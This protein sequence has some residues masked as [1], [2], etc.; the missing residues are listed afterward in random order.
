MTPSRAAFLASLP[1][2]ASALPAS[3]QGAPVLRV[4]A[5]PNDSFAEAY[6]AD[7]MGFFRRAGLD[8]R[9]S[10]FANGAQVTTG[11]AAGA[12]D[13]GISSVI[14]LAN[15]TL[16]GLPF[17]YLAGGGM[18][19]AAAPTIVLCVAK[20]APLREAR[21]LEGTTVTV[22]GIRDI[23]HLAL[24]TWLSRNG[25]DPA[26]VKVIEM[27]FSSVGAALRRGAVAAGI[28]SE[29]SL[30]AASDEVRVFAK[31]FDTI[32]AR[33]MIGGWFA[34]GD[35]IAKNRALA[36]RFAAVIH[37]TASWAN[38]NHDRSAEI[39]RKYTRIG[40]ATM[41][42]MTRVTYAESLEPAMIA[43][44]LEL[45][46]KERFLERPVSPSQMIARL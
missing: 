9:I 1:L 34:R 15:A 18:Y 3:A 39:L 8:V 36:S 41:K 31:P 24:V 21:D 29:P 33:Y 19:V 46:A 37:Q 26:K 42:R 13:V 32:G 30:T 16:H 11:V 17:A 40:E 28:I 4:G 23:T 2:L 5:T 20:D 6:Y 25:A 44:T 12:L 35:W 27:P 7:E 14:T 38:A 45:A 10:S 43:A 22:S